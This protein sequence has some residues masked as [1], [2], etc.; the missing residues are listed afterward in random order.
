MVETAEDADFI[1]DSANHSQGDGYLLDAD[2]L[3]EPLDLYVPGKC[4]NL[5]GYDPETGQE[6]ICG[7]ACNPSEQLCHFCRTQAHR[8]TGLL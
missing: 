8:T 2:D 1:D 4:M 6:E 5:L 7:D 3:D